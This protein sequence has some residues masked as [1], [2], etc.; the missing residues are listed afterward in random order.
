MSRQRGMSQLHTEG[1]R[2]YQ[3][4]RRKLERRYKGQII[5]IEPESGGYV[6]DKDELQVAFKALQRFP[7]KQFSFFRIGY[8]AVHKSH[9]A[10]FRMKVD[11]LL[12][13]DH[14]LLKRLAKA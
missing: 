4:L 5:A 14:E 2:I 6:I 7:G 3:R 10:E 9:A 1:E 8:P 12:T 13:E 11:A